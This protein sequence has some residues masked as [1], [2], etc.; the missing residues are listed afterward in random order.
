[1]AKTLMAVLDDVEKS[2][3]F[4]DTVL[5]QAEREAAHLIIYLLT[6]GPLFQPNLAPFGAYYVPDAVLEAESE[7][8]LALLRDLVGK[9]AVSIEICGLFD[10]IAWL[11]GDMRYAQP[12]ADLAILGAAPV[13]STHYLHRRITETLCLASGGPLL[14]LPPGRSVMTTNHAVFAW[15]P[16]SEAVGAL[17]DMTALLAPGARVDVVTCGHERSGDRDPRGHERVVQY[18]ERH[19]FEA[20]SVWRDRVADVAADLQTYALENGADVLAAGA[21]AHSRVREVV[22]GGVTEGLINDTRVP[23]LLSR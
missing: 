14:I 18:L 10:D 5:A 21:F 9:S 1:M 2:R 4:I 15:K 8:H 6:P 11:A 20:R 23:V 16:S 13:W 12:I 7:R 19:G 17:R 3:A 22:F